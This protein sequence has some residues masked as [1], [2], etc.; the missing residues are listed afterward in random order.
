ML[1]NHGR[2]SSASTGR[3]ATI[4]FPLASVLFEVN[5][6]DFD[7]GPSMSM[8]SSSKSDILGQINFRYKFDNRTCYLSFVFRGRCRRKTRLLAART[9]ML[10]GPAI[11]ADVDIRLSSREP[12]FRVFT[13]LPK[14][15]RHRVHCAIHLP[16]RLHT[17]WTSQNLSICRQV[18]KSRSLDI[19]ADLLP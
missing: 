18:S 19:F 12:N 3:S 7:G 14:Q 9:V 4:L 17:S 10:G 11:L 13:S 15:L 6:T 1:T 2:L 8:S 5:W 16:A